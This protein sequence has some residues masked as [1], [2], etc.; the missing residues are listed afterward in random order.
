VISVRPVELA[1]ISR[2]CYEQDIDA[3][4]TSLPVVH[5]FDPDD[6]VATT[7]HG[8]TDHNPIKRCQESEK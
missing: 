1:L 7:A 8:D 3:G 5:S 4:Q 6:P 2:W